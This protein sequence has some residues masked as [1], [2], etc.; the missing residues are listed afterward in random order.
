[1]DISDL[2]CSA[3]NWLLGTIQKISKALIRFIEW[4]TKFL[5]RVLKFIALIVIGISWLGFV[6]VLIN[7]F[8]NINLIVSNP[9]KLPLPEWILKDM[10][11]SSNFWMTIPGFAITIL[12]VVCIPTLFIFYDW[13]NKFFNLKW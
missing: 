2:V 5:I 7:Q 13:P 6:L 12:I 1:M 4:T 9:Q 3:I 8:K 11:P 10:L